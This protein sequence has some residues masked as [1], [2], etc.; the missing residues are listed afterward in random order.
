MKF[1]SVICMKKKKKLITSPDKHCVP[2]LD[3]RR[4]KLDSILSTQVKQ[5]C[6]LEFKKKRRKKSLY[7]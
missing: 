6:V 3:A 4:H 2:Q 5:Y 7:L 1:A